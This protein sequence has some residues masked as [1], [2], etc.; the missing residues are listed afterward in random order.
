MKIVAL[1]PMKGN[2]ERVPNKNLKDFFGKPLYHRVL[3][4]LLQSKYIDEVVID[5]DSDRIKKDVEENF[6]N[7]VVII[8]RPKSIVGDFVSMNKVIEYDMSQ[9]EAD[10]YLQ[11]HS[12]N[13]LLKTSSIDEALEKMIGFLENKK[14]DSIFSVTKIQTRL[15]NEDGSPLNHNP[16]ELIRTQDLPPLFEEN[17]NFFIFTKTSFE[18]SNKKRIGKNPCMF[19]IDKVQAIDIDEPEDFDIAEAIFKLINNA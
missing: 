15:Y 8:E 14:H 10:I 12:T 19:A 6:K 7:R 16:K 9:I 18:D 11:T 4:S 2:S 3:N 1:L 5:T 17:S 13:P